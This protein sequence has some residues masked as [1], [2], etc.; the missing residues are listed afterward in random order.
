MENVER[1]MLGQGELYIMPFNDIVD[2]ANLTEAEEAKLIKIGAIESGATVNIS[3]EYSHVKSYNRGTIMKFPKSTDVVF[4]TGVITFDLQNIA[5]FIYGSD[6]AVD[7]TNK[8][9]TMIIGQSD[10]TPNCYLRF[11]HTNKVDNKT[12]TVNVYRAMFTGEQEFNFN[13]NAM[14]TNYEFTALSVPMTKSAK[15]EYKFVEFIEHDPSITA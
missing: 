11:V 7:T 1:I 4:K 13:D 15:T 10:I 5:K 14:A 2:P 3:K 12:L 8:T 6:Y 9:R